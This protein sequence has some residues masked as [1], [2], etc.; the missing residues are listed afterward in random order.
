MSGDIP[1]FTACTAMTLH[2]LENGRKPKNYTCC[3]SSCH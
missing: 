3:S 1:P 2:V